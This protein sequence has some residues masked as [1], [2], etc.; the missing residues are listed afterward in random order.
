[1]RNKLIL[2]LSFLFLFVFL[3]ELVNAQTVYVTEKGKKYH[4]KNCTIVNEGKKGMELKEAQKQG[5]EPC[6]SCYSDS[7]ETSPA[8]KE[9]ATDPKKKK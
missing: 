9:E 8:K 5:Y 3:T 7:K 2:Q 4:K 1:M 6:K